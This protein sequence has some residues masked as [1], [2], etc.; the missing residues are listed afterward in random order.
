MKLRWKNT[1]KSYQGLYDEA[2]MRFE[3]SVNNAV[4]KTRSFD[5]IIYSTENHT[6]RPA[7]GK[8]NLLFTSFSSVTT[9]FTDGVETFKFNET[10]DG[11]I[12]STNE[13]PYQPVSVPQVSTLGYPGYDEVGYFMDELGS[14]I[15]F[16]NDFGEQWLLSQEFEGE[17]LGTNWEI[18]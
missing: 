11:F 3:R 7:V 4:S 9:L 17:P 2:Y 8:F 10:F 1:E 5:F 15:V 18:I 13:Q 16:K 14:D 6:H 12:D